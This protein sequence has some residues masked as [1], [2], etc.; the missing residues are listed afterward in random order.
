[1]TQ[2]V[3]VAPSVL[4]LG[5]RSDPSSEQ[6][7]A[8]LTRHGFEVEIIW[9]QPRGVA[10]PEEASRWRG[11][12]ILCFRSYFI[13]PRRLL[14]SAR[15]AAINFHPAPPEYP[16]SG[17]ANW[18]LY[19][20]AGSYGVT[21]HLMEERV[22]SGAIIEVRRFPIA[23]QDN[24]Q[25]LL[26]KTDLKL[27]DLFIDTVA[28]LAASGQAYIEKCL[29]GS[30]HEKWSGLAR[31][32]REIDSLQIIDKDCSEAELRRRVLAIHSEKYPLQINLFGYRFVLR[33]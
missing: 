4:F 10:L 24:I 31:K 17:C 26:A 12:Y 5:Q 16:G 11:D 22:D 15:V 1:M 7:I 2:T 3:R 19:D 8:C 14:E 30:G 32:I 23:P 29:A 6:A 18:A 28:G 25:T 9:S 27:L 13:L 20:Q 21:A 33:L